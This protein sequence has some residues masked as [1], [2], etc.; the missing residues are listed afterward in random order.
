MRSWYFWE[1]W[2]REMY[3]NEKTMRKSVATGKIQLIVGIVFT[4]FF[5]IGIGGGLIDR[6]GETAKYLDIYIMLTLPFLWMIYASIRKR[7]MRELARRLSQN[8]C[9]DADGY[10]PASKLVGITGKKNEMLAIKAVEKLI[11]KGFLQNCTAEYG[12]MRVVLYQNTGNDTAYTSI[13]C[14]N[15]GATIEKRVGFSQ[16]CPYCSS[17]LQ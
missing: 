14:P 5:F 7:Q 9:Q 6:S 13:I 12:T 17:E 4:V 1:V 15:C 2:E 11:S 3:I 10:I 16:T 8:F